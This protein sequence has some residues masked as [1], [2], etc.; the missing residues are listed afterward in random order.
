M[1][2][3]LQTL[4]ALHLPPELYRYATNKIRS[5]LPAT[6]EPSRLGAVGVDAVA[7]A[8]RALG[9]V[10]GSG[11]DGAR[12]PREPK[13]IADTYKET[14][15]T[16]LRFC[17]VAEGTGVAP[18]WPHLANATKGEQHV[19]ITQ[20]L[21]RACMS[22]G[23]STELFVPVITTT[24]K[25]MVIGFQF[26]G[27]GAD[28]LSSGCQPFM[29]AYA[30]SSNHYVALASATVGNQLSQGKQ[31]ASLADY[32]TI[33]DSERIKSPR[34]IFEVAITLTRFAILCQCLFQG[35][36]PPQHPFVESMWAL[37][38][39]FQNSTPFIA[40][41]YNQLSRT[42]GLGATY[43]ARI[44]RAIQLS[45][46]EYFQQVAISVG[47]GVGD[48][49]LPNFAPL[50]QDLKRGTFHLSTNW[51]EIPEA[52][53]DP[54]AVPGEANSRSPS[55]RTNLKSILR[56]AAMPLTIAFDPY[57]PTVPW[58]GKIRTY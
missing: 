29:V 42:P 41:R 35:V 25:Q 34:D 45:V 27:H 46:F 2:C 31:N 51:I 53:L 12:T 33:R 49:D 4:T 56:T 37:S 14:F 16:L 13:S 19:V 48:I 8:I 9:D 26:C 24:L 5:D 58:T 38:V 32:R 18:L 7:D 1:P 40:E 44:L 22:R 15:R 23:L 39:A 52:Y 28:D 30:G 47:A 50:C 43:P 6:T 11:G 10:R 21:Q 20:E 3:G 55:V 36:G 57:G 17:N 54:V